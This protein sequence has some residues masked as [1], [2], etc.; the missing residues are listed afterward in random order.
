[1]VLPPLLAGEEGA[2][3]SDG[4]PAHCGAP[5]F[6]AGIVL[7][8]LEDRPMKLPPLPLCRRRTPSARSWPCFRSGRPS[9][10]AGSRPW[11]TPNGRSGSGRS[12]CGAQGLPCSGS[13]LSRP[14]G[15]GAG[16]TVGG[17]RNAMGTCVPL[18]AA[19]RWGDLFTG[20]L[21]WVLISLRATVTLSSLRSNPCSKEMERK[22]NAQGHCTG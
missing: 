3:G 5:P 12:S 14:L 1:M 13:V 15:W 18:C 17:R 9:G 22:Q 10:P 6:V 2:N 11:P 8:S 7:P 21:V 4:V 16:A 19:D 20:W